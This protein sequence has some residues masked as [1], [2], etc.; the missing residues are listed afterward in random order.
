MV[1]NTMPYQVKMLYVQNQRTSWVAIRFIQESRLMRFYGDDYGRFSNYD[2][3]SFT[4]AR[5]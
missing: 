1:D 3:L 5:F 2:I 4:G